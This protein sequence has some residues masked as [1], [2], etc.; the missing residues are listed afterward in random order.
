MSHLE[1]RVHYALPL[2]HPKFETIRK[3]CIHTGHEKIEDYRKSQDGLF[4][5]VKCYKG[6]Q[7]DVM[8]GLYEVDNND[9]NWIEPI[10]ED[11]I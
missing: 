6:C 11:L 4:I 8:N 5:Q 10:I 9:P 1:D 3:H 7:L 2:D